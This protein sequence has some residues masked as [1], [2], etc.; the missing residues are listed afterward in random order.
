M[1]KLQE[2]WDELR[3][4]FGG[5]SGR[6]LDAL[7]PVVVF[8]AA[9]SRIGLALALG[10]SIGTALL[11]FL[12]R[13]FKKDNLFY[14]LGGVGAVLLAGGFAFISDSAVGFFLPG[15]IS[16]GMLVF[17]MLVSAAVKRPFA[18][19]TSHLTRNWPLVWYWH[20]RVRPAYSE[21]TIFWALGF[22]ARLGLEYWLFQRGAAGSLGLIRTA[23]GWPYTILLLIISY[24]YGLWRLGKLAGPSV[25]EFQSGASEPWEGQKRGF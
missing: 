9:H 22:G 8:L 13:L 20:P 21:V 14:A 18:A 12:F 4:V 3:T 23:L 10:A 19:L 1:A 25:E 16:S 17:L 24:L 11:L 2:L 5:R 7:L 6:L 15:L